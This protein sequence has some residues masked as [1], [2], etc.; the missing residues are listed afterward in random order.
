MK[1]SMKDKTSSIY[2]E[3]QIS[4]YPH[5]AP[6]PQF[7]NPWTNTLSLQCYLRWR[8]NQSGACVPYG[9]QMGLN[10]GSHHASVYLD[11]TAPLTQAKV[12]FWRCNLVIQQTSTALILQISKTLPKFLPP[13]TSHGY[14]CI[15]VWSAKVKF[16]ILLQGESES[17]SSAVAAVQG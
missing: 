15:L 12:L 4:M 8:C 17:P 2:P 13:H 9:S 6:V 11:L 1:T 16:R 5:S 7:E 10:C 3:L 14:F